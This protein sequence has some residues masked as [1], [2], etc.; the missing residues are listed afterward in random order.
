MTTV[1]DIIDFSKPHPNGSEGARQTIIHNDGV[2][3]S[4]VGGR[5][6][7]YGDFVEDFEIAI[8]D[9]ESNQFVTKFYSPD[10]IDDVIAYLPG[11]K[12]IELINQVFPK[13]FQVK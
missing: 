9:Q 10:N 6:G 4:I 2:R 7:L 3:M 12:M 8:L 1:K 13:G 5:T 11:D